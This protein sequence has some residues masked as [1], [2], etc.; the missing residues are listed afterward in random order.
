MS[1]ITSLQF[2][3]NLQYGMIKDVQIHRILDYYVVQIQR[4]DVSNHLYTET[5]S[6]ARDTKTERRFTSLDA[7]AS[8]IEKCGFQIKVFRCA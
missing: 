6:T 2:K 4:R 7:A 5:L 1:T 8:A 3:T